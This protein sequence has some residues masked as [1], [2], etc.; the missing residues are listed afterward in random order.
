MR[1]HVIEDARDR[2]GGRHNGG[3]GTEAGAHPS[4]EG[5]QATV[6]PPGRLGH[7][8]Q[9]LAGPIACLEGVATQDFA[10]RDLVTG[11]QPQPRTKCLL[12]G[13]LPHI[14]ADFR[15]DG[16]RG[17]GR[18]RTR[19]L[20]IIAAAP[21]ALFERGES[22]S[23]QGSNPILSPSF[24]PPCLLVDTPIPLRWTLIFLANP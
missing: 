2:V 22:A 15:Q 16:L 14:Q 8:P 1:Q 5:A 17:A 6:A 23:R 24:R 9:G 11:R 19:W 4:I 12:S 7:E 21:C 10:A 20:R 13:P 18:S 3:F